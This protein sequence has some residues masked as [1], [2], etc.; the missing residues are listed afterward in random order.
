MKMEMGQM[1]DIVIYNSPLQAH[2]VGKCFV[3]LKQ[4]QIQFIHVSHN[5]TVTI[6]KRRKIDVLNRF[7]QLFI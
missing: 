4:M 1:W 3:I 5:H 2:M 6:W 7:S